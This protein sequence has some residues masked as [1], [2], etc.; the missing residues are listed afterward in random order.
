[1]RQLILFLNLLFFT[2]SV[3]AAN[4]F[5]IDSTH[6]KQNG[7]LNAVFTCDGLDISPELHWSN[8]PEKTQS[9]ALILSDPDAPSGTFYH[10]VVYNIP[11]NTS[12]LP[13][14]IHA[15]PT[16]TREGNNSWNKATYNGPCPPKGAS[17]HYVFTL[18]ALNATLQLP[19][20]TDAQTVLKILKT[21]VIKQAQITATYQRE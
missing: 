5:G 2:L 12:G 17:H 18:Y 14:A 19:A 20:G 7:A 16:G 6:F 11:A 13:E 15:M 10:W 8:T 3:Q 1:M 9:L 4:D 21:H